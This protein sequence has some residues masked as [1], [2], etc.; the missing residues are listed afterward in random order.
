M[1]F[2]SWFGR[3]S[4][5]EVKPQSSDQPPRSPP[6][7]PPLL[8][9]ASGEPVPRMVLSGDPS[10]AHRA[11]GPLFATKY[12]GAAIILTAEVENI[13]SAALEAAIRRRVPDIDFKAEPP[14]EP[15]KPANAQRRSALTLKRSRRSKA[16]GRRCFAV[17]PTYPISRFRAWTDRAMSRPAGGGRRRARS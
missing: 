5:N 4:S 3:K 16:G 13:S 11:Q 15:T 14:A 7:E 10:V 1:V 9:S 2:K 17:S 6:D 12:R 8:L